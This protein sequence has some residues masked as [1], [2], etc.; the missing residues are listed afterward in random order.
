[1]LAGRRLGIGRGCALR[2]CPRPSCSRRSSACIACCLVEKRGY[3][4]AL[5]LL[6]DV[7]AD[8]L[9]VAPVA[10]AAVACAFGADQYAAVHL[11]CG[12]VAFLSE[13]ARLTRTVFGHDQTTPALV[14]DARVV[15]VTILA[16][17]A[18]AAEAV[19]IEIDAQILATVLTVVG[20]DCGSNRPLLRFSAAN[21]CQ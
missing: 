1:M 21:G 19:A 20:R 17:I 18:V 8:G 15:V 5:L 2:A 4:C 14:G 9:A 10:V 16:L 13:G 6:K 11:D 3:Y 12:W 7:L